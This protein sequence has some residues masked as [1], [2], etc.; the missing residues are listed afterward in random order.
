M[1]DILGDR[2]V[3]VG[4]LDV[5]GHEL[6]VLKGASKAITEGRLEHIIYEDHIGLGSEVSGFLLEQS[7]TLLRLGWRVTGLLL[8][9]LDG[10]PICKSYEHPSYLATRDPEWVAAAFAK[11][12]WKIYS[13]PGSSD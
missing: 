2:V 10:P 11:R 1:D 5:E 13:R 9:P 4:K 7:Y 6:E 8:S 3:S 12:G